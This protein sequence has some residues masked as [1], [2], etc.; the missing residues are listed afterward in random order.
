METKDKIKVLF[1]LDGDCYITGW[2]QE[3]YD[4][5]QWQTPFDTTNAVEISQSDLNGISLGTTKLIDGK[6]V[7]DTS[8]QAEL[9]SEAN[10]VTPTSEQ[11]MI[12]TLGLQ[13]AKLIEQVAELTKKL[14]G[15]S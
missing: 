5:E 15:D 14:G 13:N 7:L 12:N 11:Q 1:D 9:E 8:K 6:L 2:Q 3:F 4:G 10:K